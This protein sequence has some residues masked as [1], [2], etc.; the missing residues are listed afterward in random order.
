MKTSKKKKKA[1]TKKRGWTKKDFAFLFQHY[2]L[3]GM[4]R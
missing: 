3:P 4:Y 2:A 1:T